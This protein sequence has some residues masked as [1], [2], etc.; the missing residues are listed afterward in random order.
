MGQS[1]MKRMKR[2]AALALLLALAL[3]APALAEG[4]TVEG[5][6]LP[7]PEA[8][9]G[10]TAAPQAEESVPSAIM[11]REAQKLPLTGVKIGIDPGHQARGNNERETVAPDSTET[12]AKVTSGTAGVETRIPEYVTN[13]EIS[14]K[15]RD[16]LV[17]QGAEVYMTRE[18]NDVDIS[19]QE[20]AKLMNGYGVDLVLRI[21]CDGA[22]NKSKH[23]IALY[24][25]RSNAIAE[26]SYRAAEAI[27]P[28]LCETTGAQNNGIVSNPNCST[29]ITLMAVAGIAKL[30]PIRNM[31]ACTYQ[32]V[33]GAGQ[34]GLVELEE[35]MKD[36]AEGNE[37]RHKVFPTQ[38]ALNVIPWIG[39]ASTD[40]YTTEEMKMQNEGRR[41]LHRPELAVTCTC[42][43]V[44][45]MRSH[46]IS[47]TLRTERPVSVEEAKEAVRNFPGCR[48]FEEGEGLGY[49][50]PLDSSDQDTV[51]V[52]RIRKDLTDPN[53]LTLWCCGDQI[54]KGAAA[55]AVQI[56]K[57]L[58]G[59]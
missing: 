31:V 52:G 29:I 15:L 44:P 11:E 57:L 33:S 45:V 21:H 22:E 38:I 41:I 56:L 58:A 24:C 16:A 25:S 39:S 55:N 19:N 46:S 40:D 1:I 2:T 49:P 35:Q 14:L 37:I 26:E 12:K 32:A 36:L 5:E 13:L 6:A 7:A 43:R 34:G 3:L 20:R 28:V 48:L 9:L 30:S 54:R 8:L 10:E 53:G 27:L 42:V 17:S 59:K 51:F 47:V 23:G 4:L 18:T 50:T